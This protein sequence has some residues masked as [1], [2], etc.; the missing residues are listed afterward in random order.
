MINLHFTLVFG[1]ITFLFL[2][3]LAYLMHNSTDRKITKKK[4]KL[5]I[6]A[7]VV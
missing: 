4:N 2:T 5:E 1:N 3:I 7:K 6:N